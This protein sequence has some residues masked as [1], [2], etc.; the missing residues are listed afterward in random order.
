[1]YVLSSKA[2]LSTYIYT[3]YLRFISVY[4]GYMYHYVYNYYT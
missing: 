4:D 2:R 3:L 1:M